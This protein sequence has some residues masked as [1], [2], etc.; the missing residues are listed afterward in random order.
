MAFGDIVQNAT[1]GGAASLSFTNPVTSGNSVIIY[2]GDFLADPGAGETISVVDD[3]GASY[4]LSDQIYNNPN[5]FGTALFYGL[6]VT[7]GAKTFTMSRPSGVIF[8]VLKLA[9]IDAGGHS[10]TI[11]FHKHAADV[12][13]T[14]APTLSVVTTDDGCF[15]F[16]AVTY[17]N[18]QIPVTP[19]QTLINNDTGT[20]SLTEWFLQSSAGTATVSASSA[21]TD[22]DTILIIALS[23]GTTP[24]AS[25]V[26]PAKSLDAV[27]ASWIAEDRRL[28]PLARFVQAPT[29]PLIHKPSQDAIMVGWTSARFDVQRTPPQNVNPQPP[30][31]RA[32]P[33]LVFPEAAPLVLP[34][35][36]T[37]PLPA[38][39]TSPP[40]GSSVPE[41]V[42]DAWVPVDAFPRLR[43]PA[44]RPIA[45]NPP[46]RLSE[47]WRAVLDWLPA[48]WM[49]AAAPLFVPSAAPV[50]VPVLELPEAIFVSWLREQ[51]QFSTQSRIA[52]QIL[53][54]VARPRPLPL[55]AV[56]V[57]WIPPDP[58]PALNQLMTPPNTPPPVWPGIYPHRSDL[59]LRSWDVPAYMPILSFYV[60]SSGGP[61]L[62][63]FIKV[64]AI[65]RPFTSR[66]IVVDKRRW[67][68]P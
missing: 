54:P 16:G 66:T 59:I 55:D 15:I 34:R 56:Y 11:T 40:V 35:R 63:V 52:Q 10:A 58:R 4:T 33:V 38:A 5:F 24:P 61:P 51:Q 1:E 57:D 8:P 23:P 62:P 20:Q 26:P 25:F 7:N 46:V 13:D 42:L 44:P 29:Q 67:K 18:G 6:N 31:N 65:V 22:N 68:M 37:P 64:R 43:L 3:L 9:E 39:T 12:Q 60:L 36:L 19:G 28:P 14:D 47:A 48:S 27:L 49:P 30:P 45:N 50:R 53:P 17:T 2:A 32:R 21:T 41:A